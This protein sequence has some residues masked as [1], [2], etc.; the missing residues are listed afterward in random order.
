MSFF[1]FLSTICFED[2]GKQGEM[3]G[4]AVNELQVLL[5]SE[6]SG[7]LVGPQQPLAGGAFVIWR[8]LALK[9]TKAHKVALMVVGA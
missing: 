8:S 2:L 7:H 3:R 5:L 9:F 4:F 1:C 6:Q